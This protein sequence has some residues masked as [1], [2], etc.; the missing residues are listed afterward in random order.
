MSVPTPL[1]WFPGAHH[2]EPDSEA[3]FVVNMISRPIRQAT[4]V[5]VPISSTEWPYFSTSVTPADWTGTLETM[6]VIGEAKKWIGFARRVTSLVD[7]LGH[8]IFPRHAL[9]LILP[10]GKSY[11]IDFHGTLDLAFDSRDVAG[12]GNAS[13]QIAIGTGSS[14]YPYFKIHLVEVPIIS[15]SA[16]STEHNAY[17]VTL[18]DEN[19]VVSSIG[20]TGVLSGMMWDYGTADSIFCLCQTADSFG[21]EN[22]LNHTAPLEASTVIVPPLGKPRAYFF[23]AVDGTQ[24]QARYRSEKAANLSPN[25]RWAIRSAFSVKVVS[26]T[27]VV[28]V[29]TPVEMMISAPVMSPTMAAPV[30]M[31]RATVLTSPAPSVAPTGS[32]PPLRDTLTAPFYSRK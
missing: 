11:A 22:V 9:G 26:S 12:I 8:A 28:P 24:L 16:W 1:P 13:G 31:P 30:S 10:P 3:K 21:R 4:D 6:G 32:L 7:E 17:D 19:M 27:G 2:V 23:A 5:S 15:A 18:D 25:S 14:Y 20:P 29:S